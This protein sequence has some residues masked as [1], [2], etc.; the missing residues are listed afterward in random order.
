MKSNPSTNNKRYLFALLCCAGFVGSFPLGI[1]ASTTESYTIQ[2]QTHTVL[3]LVK[4]AKGEPVIGA[5]VRVKGSNT[6]SITDLDGRFKISVPGEGKVTLEISYIGY[7]T[8]EIETVPGK[9]VIVQLQEDSQSLEEVVVVGYGT[10]RKKDL[11]GSVIQI[12]PDAL[13]NEA[14]KT[15][16]DV[17]R[18]TPGLNVG[19]DASAKGGGS[20]QVRGQRSIYTSGGHNDPLIILD[21]MQ[22]Y[23]ELSEINPQDIG[24]IDVLK[25]ASAAAVY[26][27]KGAN[28]V[29][30]ITTKKGKL[31]KPTI[32]VTA[33]LG[34]NTR[35]DYH[36]VFNPDDYVQYLTDWHKTTTYGVNPE[37]GRY[38]AYQT[39]SH[40]KQPGYYDNPNKLAPYGITQDQW[41]AYSNNTEGES[42]R[43]I[44]G[45]R[46][47]MED[48]VLQNFIDGKT[49]DWYDKTFRTG[50]NQDYNASISGASD[51]MNYYM[52][53]G[54]L[55]N[56]G[57]IVGNDYSAMRANLK[58]SG[59]VTDWLE[60]GANVNFQDRTDGDIA[61][62]VGTNY[63]DN[64]MLRN[65]PYANCYNE[66]GSYAQYPM[67]DQVK[68]GYNYYFERQYIDL[69]KGYTVFNTIF[70]AKVT[71]PF[72]LKYEF[73]VAPR[74]QFFYDRYFTSA[75]RPDSN[76]DTEGAN[77]EQSK[78]FDWS[79]NNTL[80]WDH[81]FADKHHVILTLVQEAEERRF[82]Q[83][84]IEARG[85][86]PSDALGFHNTVNGTKD[87]SNFSSNDTHETAAAYM[88]R[89]FYSYDERYMITATIRRDGYCAFGANNPWATFPS[90]SVAWNFAN[91]KF[92]NWAPMSTGKLRL[93]WGKNGNRSLADPYIALSNLGAGTGA[94][95][96][97][98]TANGDVKDMKYLSADRLA[99]P[100]LQW[101]KTEA[102]NIGFDFGFFDDR[103]TGSIEGYL[104]T[105]H[106]MIMQQRLP[107]FSGFS[108]ITTNLGEVENRGLELTLS[109]VNFDREDFKWN[110]S[111]SLSWNKNRIKHLYYEMENITDN[112]GNVIGQREMDDKGNGW[113]INQ[114]IGVI[115]AYKVTGIWQTDEVE[116]AA[117]YGQRPGDPKVE[118]SYT[119][120]D[121]VNSDGTRT[122]VFNDYD[123]Q[124]LGQTTPKVRLSLRKDFTLWKNFDLSFSLYSHLGHKSLSG[125]YLNG[126][127][128]GSLV[129]YT[130]NTFKKEYWTPE[131]PTNKYARLNAAGP[132]G[133]GSPAKLYDRSFVRFDNLSLAYTLPQRL[134]R[135]WQM[136]RVKFYA[137]VRN[138]GC[139]GSWEYGD[140]ETGGL[141]TRTYT[142]G[143][144]LTF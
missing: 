110:T 42:L 122:P 71:L 120:D 74:Y 80:T 82:W 37:T 51:K 50:I 112:E 10:M 126:D 19:Y 54:Y 4:D 1:Q 18:G 78:R 20:L 76:P 92:F 29:I 91:E 93:S 97:Y 114:P 30:V 46:L 105:T 119:L 115:W 59:K 117:K 69:E 116:E 23:G 84:R 128:D 56:E 94:S 89:L 45:R 137:T 67:G 138:L 3:G 60:I 63:W 25:D 141:A 68:R 35:S 2:Q 27:A 7:V 98:I 48:A 52:S 132:S 73:N 130:F 129:T 113:F 41:A 11:T 135:P 102:Y 9:E 83:D 6:G 62:N 85:I 79:L 39:G 58:V 55:K 124:F 95:M 100:N 43:S 66:D 12:R 31:G 26:G 127:N 136:E 99:N 121:K 47:G 17:M 108:N 86:Q 5:S 81:T 61:V 88:G 118:N 104:M 72:G 106:D 38:E 49:F 15:V 44:W 144:N 14:P 87:L 133:A 8:Q 64:N 32:N 107:D 77:R 142:F 13:A 70:N 123:K 101:E 143:L 22:F 134:T 28:G 75:E 103:L 57:A 125:N 16:Q 140:P 96:G 90:V 24:Q 36:D 34:I 139:W 40:A 21:G 53:F 111:F 65:S 33:T 131:N 109:S